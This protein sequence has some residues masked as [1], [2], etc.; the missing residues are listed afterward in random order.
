MEEEE[1]AAWL[2]NAE[3]M[4]VLKLRLGD[5]YRPSLSSGYKL[6]W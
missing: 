5:G 6:S 3:V 4:V 2:E 1:G